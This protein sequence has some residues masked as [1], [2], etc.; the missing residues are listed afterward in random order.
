VVKK[1]RTNE[2]I[3]RDGRA[4]KVG[5]IKLFEEIF[6][7]CKSMKS[8]TT[9]AFERSFA[10][11]GIENTNRMRLDPSKVNAAICNRGGGASMMAI[12]NVV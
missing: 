6:Y 9:I 10:V 4:Q 1:W 5:I 2:S 12:E 11:V 3:D 7:F 8:D